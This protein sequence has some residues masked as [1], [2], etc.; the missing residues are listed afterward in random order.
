M[1]HRSV[2]SL[3]RVA[4]VAAALA[5]AHGAAAAAFFLKAAPAAV[6]MPD[7]RTVPI[8]GY[9]ECLDATFLVCGPVTAPGPALVVPDADPAVTITLKNELP[10][11]TSLVVPAQAGG[12]SP[13]FVDAADAP[14]SFGGRVPGDTTSRVRSFNTEAIPA[15]AGGPDVVAYTWAAFA[16]GTWLYESGTDPAIQV[17]M[18]LYGAITRDAAPGEA[19]AGR[20]YS[21]GVTLLYSE[22][23]PAFHDAVVTPGAPLDVVHYRAAYFLLNG[24]PYVAAD[25]PVVVAGIQGQA[26][27]TLLRLLNAG[28]ESRVP[29]LLGGDVSVIAQDGKPLASPRPITA[30]QLAAGTTLDLLATF[31]AAGVYPFF[32]RRLGLTTGGPAPGWSPWDGGALAP[33]LILPPPPVAVP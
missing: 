22:I 14:T 15:A 33:L 20:S 12:L 27:P 1:T 25:M 19:Y 10:V 7:G 23:D 9:A 6:T 17:Q 26:A 18:G 29:V 32:D 24:T 30:P 21:T 11:P 4:V 28:L 5:S 31:P 13:T 2:A 8:W 16:P 3:L